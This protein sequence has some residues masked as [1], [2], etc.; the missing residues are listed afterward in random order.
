ML[1]GEQG[2]YVYIGFFRAGEFKQASGA[3]PEQAGND[4]VRKLLN[5][6]VV[7]VRAFVV[8][9]AAIGDGVFQVRNAGVQM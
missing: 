8:E 5:A 1:C 4:I 6:N 3:K 2:A 7:D 9:L